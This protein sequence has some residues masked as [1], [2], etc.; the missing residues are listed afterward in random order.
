MRGPWLIAKFI[1]PDAEILYVPADQVL[2]VAG[3]EA[4]LSFDAPGARYD[5]RERKCTSEVLIDEHALTGDPALAPAGSRRTCS[6]KLHDELA[7]YV[8]LT[9]S[10]AR[11]NRATAHW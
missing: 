7:G 1:D 11:R 9:G 2:E 4:A 3:R 10:A 8:E 6:R 5:H